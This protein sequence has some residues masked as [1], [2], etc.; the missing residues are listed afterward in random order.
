MKTVIDTY[1]QTGKRVCA[2][3]QTVLVNDDGERTDH[4]GILNWDKFL[5][6]GTVTRTYKYWVP[7]DFCY[8]KECYEA[9]GG[10]DFDLSLYEDWDL[11]LRLLAMCDFKFSGGYGTAYRLNTGGLSSLVGQR[12]YEKKMYVF[13]KNKSLLNYSLFERAV[14]YTM[15]KLALL[16]AKMCE[17]GGVTPSNCASRTPLSCQMAVVA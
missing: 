10:Y 4:L 5:R 17:R 13:D 6:F 7:R 15:M 11:N 1:E 2:Y 14:F 16:K 12:H 8:P 9:C 3:S